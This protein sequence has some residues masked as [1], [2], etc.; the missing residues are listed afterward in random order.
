MLTQSEEWKKMRCSKKGFQMIC[1][2]ARNDTPSALT[3]FV[4]VQN[5]TENEVTCNREKKK[6]KKSI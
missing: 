2:Y 5:A 4:F 1:V 6:I 3:L